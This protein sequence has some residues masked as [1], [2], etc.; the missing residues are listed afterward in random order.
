MRENDAVDAV[1]RRTYLV[2]LAVVCSFLPPLALTASSPR[3]RDVYLVTFMVEGGLLLGAIS[4]RL[5]QRVIEVGV[6]T[7]GVIAFTALFWTEVRVADPTDLPTITSLA[8]RA[9]RATTLLILGGFLMLGHR[10]GLTAAVG[11]IGLFIAVPLLTHAGS[12]SLLD[13][14]DNQEVRLAMFS[15]AAVT[16]M[17]WGLARSNQL[18]TDES[19]AKTQQ[20]ALAFVDQ[21]TMLRNRRGIDHAVTE[22]LARPCDAEAPGALILIDVDHFKDF[23]DFHGH[24]AGDAALHA[25]ARTLEGCLRDGDV[26][27]RWGGEEFL[28]ILPDANMA[29]ARLVAERCRWR[30]EQL[31]V[32][33]AITISLGVAV[34]RADDTP[35]QIFQRVDQALYGAKHGGRNQVVAVGRRGARPPI[36]S[37]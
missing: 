6:Y 11:V 32:P 1:R 24:S 12:L 29:A 33:S 15:A 18:L 8:F 14:V 5:P 34:R 4:R 13:L 27:G 19:S 22:L 28:V 31:E 3:M 35:R 2:L 23:N 30:V 17:A 7:T 20:A 36:R 9:S 37:A 26:A 25:V 10:R 21:L 16:A